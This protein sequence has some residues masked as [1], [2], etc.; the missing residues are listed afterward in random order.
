VILPGEA[1]GY[2]ARESVMDTVAEMFDWC[3]RFV[4]DVKTDVGEKPMEAGSPR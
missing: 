2:R 3:D 1:H 4:R